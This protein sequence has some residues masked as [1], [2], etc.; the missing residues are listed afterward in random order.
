MATRALV[1]GGN[2]FIGS[3]L[4]ERLRADGYAPTVLDP[5]PPRA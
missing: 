3:H 1:V 4:V 5:G 2:G